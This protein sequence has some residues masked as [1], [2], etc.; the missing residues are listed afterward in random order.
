MAF[1]YKIVQRKSK[2]NGGQQIQMATQMSKGK[3]PIRD[4][5]KRLEQ[6]TSLGRGD[7]MNVLTHLG[8]V[9]SEYMRLGYSVNL[10]ELGTFTPRISSKSVPA[11]EKFTSDYIRGVKMRFTP[12]TF[13]KAELSRVKFECQ[14][15]VCKAPT[16]STPPK[17]ET[18]PE[19]GDTAI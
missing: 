1:E 4:I 16:T 11:G 8:E 2:L 12:S 6:I 10:H 13:I 19:E 5:A 7:V 18:T 14:A 15:D 17:E 9:V 3:V